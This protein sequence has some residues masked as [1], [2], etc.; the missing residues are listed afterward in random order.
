[1]DA[2]PC[3]SSSADLLSVTTIGRTKLL[4]ENPA[5]PYLGPLTPLA[6][7]AFGPPLVIGEEYQRVADAIEASLS[8]GMRTEGEEY[9]V[10]VLTV[11]DDP[12]TVR[13]STPINSDSTTKRS[14]R[15]W[16]WTLGQRYTSLASLTRPGVTTTSQL[17]DV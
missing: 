17:E 5:N 8:T 1:M 15:A 12:E 9:G 6:I 11:P 7:M 4:Q 10:I 3:T 14:G 13:L 2:S 16:A